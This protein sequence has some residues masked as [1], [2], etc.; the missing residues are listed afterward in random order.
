MSHTRAPGKCRLQDGDIINID[1]AVIKDGWFGDTS[2]MYFVGD[3]ETI[4]HSFLNRSQNVL[5]SPR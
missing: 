3:S 2:R 1:V 5:K 4:S